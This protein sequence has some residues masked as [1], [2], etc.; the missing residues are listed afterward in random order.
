MSPP[1]CIGCDPDFIGQ[2]SR[3]ACDD[4]MYLPVY[5]T[6]VSGNNS[7]TYIQLA[8]RAVA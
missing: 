1:N 3:A 2:G 8:G 6:V 5:Y 4:S 7:L